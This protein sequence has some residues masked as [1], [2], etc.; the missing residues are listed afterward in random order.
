MRIKKTSQYIEGGASISNVYGTS[1]ENGYTQ[2]YINEKV[3][4]EDWSSEIGTGFGCYAKRVGNLVTVTCTNTATKTLNG[5]AQTP[6]GSLSDKYKPSK[7]L[8][9]AVYVRGSNVVYGNIN[10]EGTII[11]FNWGNAI[12]NSEAGTIGFTIT[13]IVD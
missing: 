7:S 2:D 11:L 10:T 5:Y 12:S 1:Q 8:R 3:T 9:F 13:Y 4:P 6:I